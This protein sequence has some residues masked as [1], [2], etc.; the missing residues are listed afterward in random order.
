MMPIGAPYTSKPMMNYCTTPLSLGFLRIIRCIE[1][2]LSSANTW[3]SKSHLAYP[4]NGCTLVQQQLCCSCMAVS[5]CAME[6]SFAQLHIMSYCEPMNGHQQIQASYR[7]AFPR[8][9]PS[10]ISQIYS[11]FSSTTTLL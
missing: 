6:G 4:V 2:C 10:P 8:A 9:N 1:P 5:C 3:E 11:S 7:G